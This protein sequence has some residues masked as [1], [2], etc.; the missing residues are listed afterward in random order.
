MAKSIF[1]QIKKQ[2]G[3]TFAKSIRN[4]DNGIFDIRGIVDIVKYAGRDAEPIMNY[5]ISLKGIKI[6]E[7]GAYEDPIK[8]LD[9][10]G[11]DAYYADTLEKQNAIEK[12]YAKGEHLCTFGDPTRFKRYYIINAV[13][14]DVDKIRR[15]DF[16]GK[17]KRDDFEEHGYGTSVLS[18]Q[19][20]KE[21]GF[22]SIKNRY[23]HTV[24][25][26]DNTLNSNPDN[27]IKGLSESL[28]NFFNVD[29]SAQRVCIP[30]NYR[31]VNNQ[32]IR[33]NFERNNVYFGSDF[34]V[35]NGVIHE[36]DKSKEIML[37]MYILNLKD[38]TVWNPSDDAQPFPIDR[39]SDSFREEGRIFAG[40]FKD[41]NLSV[42]KNEDG[43]RNVNAD[44]VLIAKVKNGQI[45]GL[46]LPTT[47]HI[48]NYFFGGFF[49][50]GVPVLR[51]FSA[52]ELED[53]GL[54]FLENAK[55]LEKVDLPKVRKMRDYSFSRAHELVDFNAPELEE[56]GRDFLRENNKLK[57]LDLPKLVK[58]G[59]DFLAG[60][61]VLEEFNAPNL[62]EIDYNEKDIE[63]TGSIL[64][65]CNGYMKKMYAPK[66]PKEVVLKLYPHMKNALKQP[67]KKR[68]TMFDTLNSLKKATENSKNKFT[69]V[70][71]TVKK[72]FSK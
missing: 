15:E 45:I 46:N 32:I 49:W 35:K 62:E 22:I 63:T 21:G 34:Y 48:G 36:L 38:K 13:R 25:N 24:G 43:S 8:L 16:R 71:K 64:L 50:G 54:L 57:K 41:K 67:E 19:M 55:F 2:N 47:K 4:Y 72:I 68:S 10:A 42:T 1:E 3:E 44:G 28:K 9:R 56:V 27:I 58:V 30:G 31:I 12:Y 17:E 14:K 39:E 65:S 37:D 23:N 5:L 7:Q 66:L 53:F 60:N 26:P 11:Y 6:E 18:I 29:F 70:V 59:R 52:P 61:M 51:E 40:E 69:T 20:R 33:Y